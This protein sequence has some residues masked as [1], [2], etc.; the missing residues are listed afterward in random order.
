MNNGRV[1][2]LNGKV[3]AITRRAYGFHGPSALVGLI[4]LC[5]SGLTLTPQHVYPR[6]P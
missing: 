4:F 3:R 5:C 6:L 1:E 2:G